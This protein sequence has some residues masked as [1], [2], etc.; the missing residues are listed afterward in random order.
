M[1]TPQNHG[2]EGVAAASFQCNLPVRLAARPGILI[3]ASSSSDRLKKRCH[4]PHLMEWPALWPPAA[5][6]QMSNELVERRW[7]VS[8]PFC[9]ASSRN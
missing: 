1:Y 6:A 2:F 3:L 9:V 8:L 5:R 7:S 4:P